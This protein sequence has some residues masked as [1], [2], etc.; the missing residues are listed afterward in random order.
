[1]SRKTAIIISCILFVLLVAVM[2]CEVMNPAGGQVFLKS[3]FLTEV[4][5]YVGIQET[6]GQKEAV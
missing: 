1:M 3:D 2:A 4:R 6:T 5:I